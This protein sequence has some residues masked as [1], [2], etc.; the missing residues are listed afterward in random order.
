MGEL[1]GLEWGN[2]D[3]LAGLIHVVKSKSGKSRAIPIGTA[4]AAV[5]DGGTGGE[6]ASPVF[7]GQDGRPYTARHDRRISKATKDA[8]LAAGI[9]GASFHTIRH[10]TASWMVQAGRPLDRSARRARSRHD[11][12][13]SPL[14][15]PATRPSA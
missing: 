7:V 15:P 13:D 12:D 11:A 14:R 1:A 8:M 9:A 10:T 3:R 4:A 5:L 2:V 6:D